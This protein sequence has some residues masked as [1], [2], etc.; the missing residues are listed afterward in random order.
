MTSSDQPDLSLAPSIGVKDIFVTPPLP[1]R[2]VEDL[3]VV[4]ARACFL[5]MALVLAI[6]AVRNWPT[7]NGITLLHAVTAGI[8]GVTSVRRIKLA[9]RGRILLIGIAVLGSACIAASRNESAYIGGLVW[10]PIP[11]LFM[12]VFTPRVTVIA[13]VMAHLL[14][15]VVT[16]ILTPSGIDE[17]VW[18]VWGFIYSLLAAFI[19]KTAVV[20]VGMLHRQSEQDRSR[21]EQ[22]LQERLQVNRVLTEELRAPLSSLVALI[23]GS[24]AQ[25]DNLNP[26]IN[27]E[28]EHLSLIFDNLVSTVEADDVRPIKLTAVSITK[29]LR[30][31]DKQLSDAMASFG[32]ELCVDIAQGADVSVTTDRFRLRAAIGNILRNIARET[33]GHRVWLNAN[34]IHDQARREHLAITIEDNGHAAGFE[35]IEQ[36]MGD[37]PITTASARSGVLGLQVAR[38]WI[39]GL[40]GTLTLF[41]SPHGGLGFRICLL[42]ETPEST[43]L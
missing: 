6:A 43:A 28:V 30:Q 22:L 35:S 27:D 37:K 8:V 17:A 32:V 15:L 29:L 1:S 19:A 21:I 18:L 2:L 39:E 26:Q 33:D 20:L 5:L 13:S 7:H 25:P 11:S 12:L 41:R 36:V 10:S 40:G 24:K 16:W 14:I 34:K 3:A 9:A 38:Q 31:I 42:M 4:A 23:H